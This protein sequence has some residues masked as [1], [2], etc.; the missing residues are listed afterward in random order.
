[1]ARQNSLEGIAEALDGVYDVAE[2]ELAASLEG[3]PSVSNTPLP[4][5]PENV[6]CF[7]ESR[8][9]QKRSH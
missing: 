6:V 2:F 1:M 8:V 3:T 9:K 4:S 5:H 7:P